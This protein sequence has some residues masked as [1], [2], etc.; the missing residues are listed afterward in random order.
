MKSV[1]IVICTIFI[2][3]TWAANIHAA[4]RNIVRKEPLADLSR[5][6]RVALVI[7]NGA[8]EKVPL[9][10]P[11]HDAEDM[12]A[13]LKEIGFDVTV[14]SNLKRNEMRSVLRDFGNRLGKEAVGLFFFAG[15]GIQVQNVNYLLPI[16]ADIEAEDEVVD[17]AIDAN[18]VMRKMERAGNPLNL[19]ILDACRNNPY[20]HSW[21]GMEQGLARMQAP[22]GTLIIYATRPG[23]TAKDGDDRNSP[24]TKEFILGM[25]VPGLEVGRMIRSIAVKVEEATGGKQTP[26]QEGIIKGEFYFIP[27]EMDED[28]VVHPLEPPDTT[29]DNTKAPLQIAHQ[30]LEPP[31]VQPPSFQSIEETR[32][33]YAKYKDGTIVDTQLRLHWRASTEGM[34]SW[35]DAQTYIETINQKGLDGHHDWRIPNKSELLRAAR[36]AK[37]NPGF[38]MLDDE[39]FWSDTQND[40]LTAWLVNMGH[41]K[42][43]WD[44]FDESEKSEDF[45]LPHAVRLVR[46]LK[47]IN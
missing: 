27:A 24:F 17:E 37:A 4:E 16:D 20:A 29:V 23:E 25:R 7:G 9:R 32:G 46:N 28:D 31:M 13:T 39:W 45:E 38:F 30:K 47:T 40:P 34:M 3:S 22:S 18:L 2:L 33:P 5:A 26:W 43:D 35:V 12:A 41:A 10:N 36:F 1:Q 11:P 19:V 14:R 21:R 44:D 8:Y 42:V 15:H 6:A